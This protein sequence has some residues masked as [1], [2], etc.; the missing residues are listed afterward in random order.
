MSREQVSELIESIAR[1]NRDRGSSTRNDLSDI[2]RGQRLQQ[3]FENNQRL[4]SE[5]NLSTEDL[6]RVLG[7]QSLQ[8]LQRFSN[9]TGGQNSGRNG[10][11]S[12]LQEIVS[13]EIVNQLSNMSGEELQ[14]IVGNFLENN[15]TQGN[16]TQNNSTNQ[17]QSNSRQANNQSRNSTGA[18]SQN[19]NTT[20]TQRSNSGRN[21]TS[22]STENEALS[23]ETIDRQINRKGWRAILDVYREV[24]QDAEASTGRPSRTSPGSAARE[25]ESSLLKTFREFTGRDRSQ[26][27]RSG[28]TRSAQSRSGAGSSRSGSASMSSSTSRQVDSIFRSAMRTI[29]G[30]S[31]SGSGSSSGPGLSSVLS[32]PSSFSGGSISP[33]SAEGIGGVAIVVVLA[34]AIMGAVIAFRFSSSRPIVAVPMTAQERTEL[35]GSIRTRADLVRAYHR[36]ALSPIRRTQPWWTHR[37]FETDVSTETPVHTDQISLLTDIYEEARYL[38]D[39]AELTDSQIQQARRAIQLCDA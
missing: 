14:G 39:N 28:T 19:R 37:R 22:S 12:G 1:Q 23:S 16:S 9:R 21:G 20:N 18:T 7:Q 11:S 13:Q 4:L 15:S 34:L 6:Q 27:T 5:S 31:S 29:N 24:K 10:T 35:A 33:P 26:S 3:L 30:S 38:P 25:V 2:A 36:F 32:G 17:T 8:N